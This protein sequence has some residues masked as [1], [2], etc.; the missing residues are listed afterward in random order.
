M[1]IPKHLLDHVLYFEYTN[2][3]PSYQ[4]PQD[5]FTLH[6]KQWWKKKKVIEIKR[7][8]TEIRDDG[9]YTHTM[10]DSAEMLLNQLNDYALATFEDKKSDN[11]DK[12]DNILKSGDK[13]KPDA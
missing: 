11:D 9:G 3:V 12:I 2:Y 8:I 6:F 1:V 4:K 7:T 13:L 5:Q 10:S